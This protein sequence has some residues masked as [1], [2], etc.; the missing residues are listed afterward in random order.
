MQDGK[1]GGRGHPPR[2]RHRNAPSPPFL[3][4][5]AVDAQV[6]VKRPWKDTGLGK[7]VGPRFGCLP[8]LPGFA[9]SILATWGPPFSQPL[10]LDTLKN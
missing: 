3:W 7:K 6:G 9:R 10:Y 8:P 5:D 4:T 2:L 1:K